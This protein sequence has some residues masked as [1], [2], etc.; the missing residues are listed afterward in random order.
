MNGV[1]ETFLHDIVLV[2]IIYLYINDIPLIDNY[3]L[4]LQVLF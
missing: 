1:F 2:Y 4:C 3:L